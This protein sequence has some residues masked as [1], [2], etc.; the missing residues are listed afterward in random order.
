MTRNEASEK[1]EKLRNEVIVQ[2]AEISAI[3]HAMYEVTACGETP[4]TT[5]GDGY[6]GIA[7]LCAQLWE[8]LQ[9]IGRV[10][11]EDMTP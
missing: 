8:K 10:Y 5:I 11:E 4:E 9:E 2:S 1:V 3:A 6:H 7:R